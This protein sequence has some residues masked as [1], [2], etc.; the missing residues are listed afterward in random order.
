MYVIGIY[1]TYIPYFE[2]KKVYNGALYYTVIHIFGLSR[3]KYV[4]LEPQIKFNSKF[5]L[6]LH[7][8]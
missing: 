8:M 7:Y 4:T 6:D 5:E 3:V 2:E 1:K